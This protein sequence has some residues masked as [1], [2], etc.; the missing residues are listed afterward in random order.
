MIN[1]N[2]NDKNVLGKIKTLPVWMLLLLFLV[3]AACELKKRVT[4]TPR[5]YDITKPE[6]I[7]LGTKLDEISGI[8][9][10]NDSLILANNDEA[11][12]IFA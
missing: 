2:K 12:R 4:Y 6:S 1:L 7:K 9:W 3:I 11:G 5:G 10:I 8:C